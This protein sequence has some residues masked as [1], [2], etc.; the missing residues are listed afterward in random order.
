MSTIN[1]LKEK[2]N[3]INELVKTQIKSDNSDLKPI[4]DGIIDVE[5]FFRAK[6]KIMWILKEPYDDVDDDGKPYC[7]GWDLCEL[8]KNTE[9]FEDFEGGKPTFKQMIYTS[10]GILND[11]CIFDGMDNIEDNPTMIDALKSVAIINIKKLPGFTSSQNNIIESTYV[12][13]KDIL[14]K[15]IEYFNPDI[16]IGGS[17]LYNFYQDFGFTKEQ[18]KTLDSVNYITKNNKIFIAAYHPAQRPGIT[19]ISYEKYCDDIINAAK[20]SL[21]K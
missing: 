10:W 1:E 3:E 7:A 6:Y 21:L 9:K 19:G 14:L 8:I 13:Y 11:F 2:I 17:T 4:L 5:K 20:I 16:I 18:M 15:Q 12:Q